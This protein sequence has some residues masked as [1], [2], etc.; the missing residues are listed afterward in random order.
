MMKAAF[1]E[2]PGNIVLKEVEVPKCG[3]DD[4]LV[5]IKATG[6]CG[7]DLH[8]FKEGR[9]G[10]NIVTEPHILG[11]ESAGEIVET[12]G[13]VSN[14]QPGDRVTIEPGV[15][16]LHC[17]LCLSGRYNLC[18]SVRFLGAPPNHGTFREYIA[19]PALFV[20]PL[21]EG[22]SF[23]EGALVEPFAVAYHAL[24]KAGIKPG[25]SVLIIGAGTIGLSC[26]Q[27]VK[28]AGAAI[29]DIVDIDQYRLETAKKIGADNCVDA[30]KG[31]VEEN[32][33]DC[34]IE[35]AGVPE[36]YQLC[37]D[38]MKKGGRL[39]LVGMSN[40]PTKTDF[41]TMLRKEAEVFMVY[42]YANCY[43]P[44]LKLLEAGKINSS[45]M[46]SHHY[47]LGEIQQAFMTAE[48]P[49]VDKLK[50]IIE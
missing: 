26:L 3:E 39:V 37:V 10:A 23:T 4:V 16:C 50:I 36:S 40:T 6:V 45:A 28:I 9:V 49:S 14:L 44:V 29:V 8:Y 31:C 25:E 48:D 47:P 41:M 32:S 33:Y 30:A 21:P 22:V 24:G 20:H 34:V 15:P 35:A 7:S 12:G 46:V 18:S 11:H 19:H 17:E 38:S 13:N 1:L 5:R 42:R 2:K 27:M 43:K